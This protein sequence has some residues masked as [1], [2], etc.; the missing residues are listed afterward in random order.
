MVGSWMNRMVSDCKWRAKIPNRM[1]DSHHQTTMHC[2]P[3]DV[4]LLSSVSSNENML[5]NRSAGSGTCSRVTSEGHQA[6]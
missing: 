5:K 1:Q 6:S 2:P 3:L 4:P